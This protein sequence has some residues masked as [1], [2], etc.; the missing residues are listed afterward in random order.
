MNKV[1][2]IYIPGEEDVV[3]DSIYMDDGQVLSLKRKKPVTIPSK[4]NQKTALKSKSTGK[5]FIKHSPQFTKWKKK[6]APFWDAQYMKLY[7]QG[8]SLP[9]TRCNI[10]I[11]FY[12]ATD[13]S[14][15]TQNKW[16]TIADALVDHKIVAQDN[17]QV[18]SETTHKGFVCKHRPRTE[19]YITII[20][21]GDPDFD[22]DITDY[23]KLAQIKKK[24][25]KER[26]EFNKLKKSIYRK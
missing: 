20:R 8:Y 10:N 7:E 24:Q 6:M 16:E 18:L 15:D 3:V 2:K 25:L 5:M 9:I 22:Y 11:K 21:P 12:F 13:V 17:V 4:K 1:I 26:Y 23:E 19:L 14:R